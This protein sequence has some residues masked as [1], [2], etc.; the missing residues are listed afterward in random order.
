MSKLFHQGEYKQLNRKLFRCFC[1]GY[2]IFL[3]MGVTVRSVK[4][5]ASNHYGALYQKQV[6]A[7]ILKEA[8]SLVP[9]LAIIF[10]S[11]YLLLAV[12][13]I[14]TDIWEQRKARNRK[15]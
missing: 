9:N 7:V 13:L 14:L 6:L 3:L 15:T 2:I 11:G 4:V 1:E 5:I 10:F 12:I 8:K